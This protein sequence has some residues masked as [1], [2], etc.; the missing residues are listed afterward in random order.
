M[1]IFLPFEVNGEPARCP[2]NTNNC[3]PRHQKKTQLRE[4]G[5][6]PRRQLSPLRTTDPF[7][8]QRAT[9]LFHSETLYD[10]RID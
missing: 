8:R 3:S 9:D 5:L 7:V 4:A 6:L 2:M 1:R 10:C